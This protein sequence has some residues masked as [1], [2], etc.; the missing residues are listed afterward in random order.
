V[1]Q[2]GLGVAGLFVSP[3]AALVGLLLAGIGAGAAGKVWDS[4]LAGQEGMVA[5]L[6]RAVA[7]V[8]VSVR[9]VA[10]I[11]DADRL[12]PDLAVVLVE[13][14]IGRVDGRV[15]VVAAVNPGGDL[16]S[17][18]TSRAAYGLTEGRVRT[19]NAD[20]DMDYQSRVD[21]AAELCPQLPSAATRRIGQR[22][23]TFAEVFR[24]ASTER[25]AEMD[26][27]DGDTGVVTAVDEV[28][29]AR[30]SQASPSGLAVVLAWAGGILHSLQAERV[31]R[32][33]REKLP[34]ED[35]NVL[36][37]ESLTSMIH[38]SDVLA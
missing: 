32:A 18:L 24:V 13:N 34:G 19:M 17:A 28:I 8:S 10:I 2:L 35:D 1:T 31:V 22:T 36:R 27:Q 20:P 5:R 3:L 6:A 7:A 9:V 16:I 33:L 30:A 15:L 38:R 37:F 25:L 29:D 23:Q 12:D 4:S 14:L 21:L 11:D 26:A